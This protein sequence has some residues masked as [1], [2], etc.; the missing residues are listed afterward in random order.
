MS[1]CSFNDILEFAIIDEIAASKFY[2]DMASK[3]KS[4]TMAKAFKEFAKE[5]QGHRNKLEAIKCDKTLIEN[6][7]TSAK[8]VDLKIADYAVDVEPNTD[9]DYQQ[10][11]ILAMKKEKAAYKLYTDLAQS[12]EDENISKIFLFLAQEEAKHKLHF[13][14]EYDEVV[15]K[16][17]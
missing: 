1:K 2:L 11:L 17:N 16:E 9:M 6:E 12:I 15:L 3:M 5:E 14:I 4:P 8:V 7:N 10:I 13:E